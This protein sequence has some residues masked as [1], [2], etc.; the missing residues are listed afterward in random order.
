MICF[1]ASL[2]G[3]RMPF[4]RPK[5]RELIRPV[6]LAA[7]A[8]LVVAMGASTAGR[9]Q[10]KTFDG[11]YKGSLECE[12]GGLEVFRRPLAIIIRNGRV[13]GGAPTLDIDG[14][15]EV[16]FAVGT[17]TVDPDGG[18]RLRYILYTRDY[19][20]RGDYSGTLHGGGGT[21]TGTQVF[22][23]EI[24]GD[25]ATRT[26]KGTFLQVELPKQ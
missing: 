22:T 8:L 9:A 21:L 15:Q 13:T 5:Q 7:I 4:V 24:T 10:P 17:G 19:S 3:G 16:S 2:L 1:S 12:Q 20:L 6:C 25:G 23:R 11:D 18:F 14:R 26:C